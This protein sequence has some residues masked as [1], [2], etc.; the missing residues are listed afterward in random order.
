[1][2]KETTTMKQ[3]PDR[4]EEAPAAPRLALPKA[5]SA[6]R[7]PSLC[8]RHLAVRPVQPRRVAADPG[9]SAP[10]GRIAESFDS[11]RGDRGHTTTAER[12]CGGRARW[13]SGGAPFVVMVASIRRRGGSPP[14]RAREGG[15]GT[16][17]TVSQALGLLSDSRGRA[18]RR[19]PRPPQRRAALAPVQDRVDVREVDRE[20]K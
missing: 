18:R 13:T 11:C 12:D 7:S 8:S 16:N 15:A 20:Y 3:Q 6:G 17:H 14:H 19:L 2:S 4:S 5:P 1:M 10:F 9:G